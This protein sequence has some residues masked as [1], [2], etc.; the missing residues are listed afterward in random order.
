MIKGN[1][2]ELFSPGRNSP[3][4]LPQR[5]LLHRRYVIGPTLGEGGFGITYQA[6]DEKENCRVALKEYMPMELS[7]RTGASGEVSAVKDRAHYEKYMERFLAEAQI[8]YQYRGHPNIVEVRHLFRE[9]NTA[10]YAMELLAGSDLRHILQRQPGMR[11]EWEDLKPV[12]EQTFRALKTVHQSGIT[13]CDVSPDNIVVLR[14][15]GQVKLIDFGAAKTRIGGQSTQ[16]MLKRGF[17]PPEQFVTDGYL[18]PWSDIYALGVTIYSC[19]TGRLPPGAMERLS[20][21]RERPIGELGIRLPENFSEKALQKAMEPHVANRYKDVGIFWAELTGEELDGGSLRQSDEVPE[22]KT[23][24]FSEG[25]NLGLLGRAGIWEG[26]RFRAER[27]LYAGK[28]AE[29]R[30][31]FPPEMS[32]VGSVHFRVWNEQGK[33]FLTDMNSGCATYLNY[34]RITPGLVYE[35]ERGCGIRIGENQIFEVIE[36]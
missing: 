3:R 12:F 8:I 17:A 26:E 27:F 4:A 29:C 28:T 33:L 2:R 32:G 24:P 13:H 34:R 30:I 22:A 6:W 20:G 16:V 21:A 25:G 35:L 1:L 15:N 5:Y 10:Y 9:N 23:P 31:H 14:K 19:L 11:A 36:L 18:G 7:K